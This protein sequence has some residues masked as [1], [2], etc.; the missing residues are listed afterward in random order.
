[1]W[2][3]EPPPPFGPGGAKQEVEDRPLTLKR[4]DGE[5]GGQREDDVKVADR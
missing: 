5:L 1:M 4:R 2:R 3:C